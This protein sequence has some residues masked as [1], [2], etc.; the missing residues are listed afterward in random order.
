MKNPKKT[1]IARLTALR[2]KQGL[3]QN[4]LAKKAMNSREYVSRLEK[5]VQDPTL[6]TMTKLAKALK[7]GVTELLER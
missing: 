7:V 3:T 1:F 6:R 5:G 2:R 4:A